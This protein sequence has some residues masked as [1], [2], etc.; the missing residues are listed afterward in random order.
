MN[1]SGHHIKIWVD[2]DEMKN[3]FSINNI[4]PT[5][6]SLLPPLVDY[7]RYRSMI[8]RSDQVEVWKTNPGKSEFLYTKKDNI[9]E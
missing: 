3:Y 8:I 9:N 1:Y 5:D 4:I 2:K 7:Q 6:W